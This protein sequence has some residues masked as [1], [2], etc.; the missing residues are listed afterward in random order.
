MREVNATCAL[1][2]CVHIPDAARD[3]G[4]LCGLPHR[5][6]AQAAPACAAL[7]G[8][9]PH[10]CRCSHCGGIQVR[11][12]S[13]PHGPHILASHPLLSVRLANH[14][15]AKLIR[16]T[17]ELHHHRAALM[18][19][20][21]FRSQMTI[22]CFNLLGFATCIGIVLA[23]QQSTCHR[24]TAQIPASLHQSIALSQTSAAMQ[25]LAAWA[26]VD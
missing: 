23:A 13:A 20:Q 26:G 19:K 10:H 16:L 5:H 6:P 24:S 15:S 1:Q 9:C 7:A 12:Q 4:H 8:H 2:V 3:A 17:N 22:T 21:L 14:G 18:I 11:R 25:D